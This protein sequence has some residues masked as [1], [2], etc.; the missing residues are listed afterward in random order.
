MYEVFG[1]ALDCQEHGVKNA[2]DAE[3]TPT[4]PRDPSES[5]MPYWCAETITHL[6]LI[7]YK[8]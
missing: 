8:W 5:G 3:P 2:K 7:D 6:Y 4:L 1:L